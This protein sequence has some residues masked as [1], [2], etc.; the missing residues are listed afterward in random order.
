MNDREK[1]LERVWDICATST[2]WWWWW[3]W[4]QAQ[5]FA[6]F[7]GHG[8]SIHN[9]IPQLKKKERK[10]TTFHCVPFKM[11][12]MLRTFI[13]PK[14]YHDVSWYRL[15][16]TKIWQY[17]YIYIYI[18]IYVC[19]CVEHRNISIMYFFMYDDMTLLVSFFN[20]YSINFYFS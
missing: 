10:Y 13:Y 2:T 15:T 5:V 12:F 19:V 9:I 7:S 20:F 18:Y 8:N 17:I 1:W 6:G 14:I 3:W 16:S 4:C 11:Q